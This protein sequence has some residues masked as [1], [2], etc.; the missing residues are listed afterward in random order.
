MRAGAVVSSHR[1]LGAA[2]GGHTVGGDPRTLQRA[3]T[4][5]AEDVATEEHMG[6]PPY[7]VFLCKHK[8]RNTQSKNTGELLRQASGGGQIPPY[9]FSTLHLTLLTQRAAPPQVKYRQKEIPH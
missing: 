3:E 7:S 9:L 1:A 5:R 6:Q 8:Q 4:V 2:D